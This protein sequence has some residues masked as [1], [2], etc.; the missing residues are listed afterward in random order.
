[1]DLQSLV[2][3][4]TDAI[5]NEQRLRRGNRVSYPAFQVSLKGPEKKR[6]STGGG[7]GEGFFSFFPDCLVLSYYL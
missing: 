2:G 1:M 6:F 3:I 7:G 5:V 4:P